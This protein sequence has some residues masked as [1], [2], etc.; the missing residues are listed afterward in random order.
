MG[1]HASDALGVGDLCGCKS[2]SPPFT[3]LTDLGSSRAT[4]WITIRCVSIAKP[5]AIS[6]MALPTKSVVAASGTRRLAKM[7]LLRVSHLIFVPGE[8]GT[9]ELV[10]DA[11]QCQA[12]LVVAPSVSATMLQK[13]IPAKGKAP[14][15]WT[16][17]PHAWKVMQVPSPSPGVAEASQPNSVVARPSA[18]PRPPLF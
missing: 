1:D 3:F 5:L 13:K 17:R 16:T 9:E 12:P 15:H 7:W 14:I 4:G 11:A 2:L 8:P 18:V 10:L 6:A